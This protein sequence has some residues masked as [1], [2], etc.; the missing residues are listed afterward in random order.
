LERDLVISSQLI[1]INKVRFFLDEFFIESCLKRS[2]FNRVLLGISEAVNNS[3][4]HGNKQDVRKNVFLCLKYFD[5]KLFI[6]VKDEGIGFDVECLNDPTC[7][8]NL[9]KENG[10][11][12][13]LLREIA[14]EVRYYDG[15]RTVLIKY[16]LD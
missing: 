5:N 15:G 3:I 11:G 12:I 13:F 1:N 9:K 8:D 7:F 16:N 10:R 4:V 6:E 2:Y 14:D